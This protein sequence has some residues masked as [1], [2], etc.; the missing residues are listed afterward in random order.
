MDFLNIQAGKI[1]EA[2]Q[3]ATGDAAGGSGKAESGNRGGWS[4]SLCRAPAAKNRQSEVKRPLSAWKIHFSAQ[5][6]HF[7][8]PAPRDPQSARLDHLAASLEPSCGVAGTSRRLAEPFRRRGKR[9]W[10]DG[11]R[12]AAAGKKPS[13]A[14]RQA[15]EGR[16]GW[17]VTLEFKL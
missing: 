5:K 15:G 2:R 9:I 17:C 14:R 8:R 10:P 6:N 4:S 11:G 16:S 7:C 3:L 12:V 13:A 1:A